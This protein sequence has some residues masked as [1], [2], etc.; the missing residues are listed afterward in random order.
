MQSADD[1]LISAYPFLTPAFFRTRIHVFSDASSMTE[2]KLQLR[3]K[4]VVQSG[5]SSRISRG[6]SD[7]TDDIMKM[8]SL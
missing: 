4:K 7:S 2:P 6:R 5:V 8:D 3:S 1:S